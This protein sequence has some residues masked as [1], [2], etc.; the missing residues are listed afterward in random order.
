MLVHHNDLYLKQPFIFDQL[1]HLL[2]DKKQGEP[3]NVNIAFSYCPL[4]NQS[5]NLPIITIMYANA[6]KWC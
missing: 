6:P 1:N 4:Y 2:I 5:R 3:S